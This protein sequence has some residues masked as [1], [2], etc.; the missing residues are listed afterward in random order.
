MVKCLERCENLFGLFWECFEIVGIYLFKKVWKDIRNMGFF[1][2]RWLYFWAY[3]GLKFVPGDPWECPQWI[4]E[5]SLGSPGS[6][7]SSMERNRFWELTLLVLG[8]SLLPRTII[9]QVRLLI[10]GILMT[11]RLLFL[12]SKSLRSERGLS[13]KFFYLRKGLC[14]D[15]FHRIH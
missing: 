4:W 2:S 13:K 12:I 15:I 7:F 11:H 5:P 8:I 14:M 3:F 1:C 9:A 6:S 10:I